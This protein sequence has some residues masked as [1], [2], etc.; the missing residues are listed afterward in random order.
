MSLWKEI[1]EY[2]PCSDQETRLASE[3][4]S[5]YLAKGRIT[6]TN[7]ELLDLPDPVIAAFYA[8]LSEH[9]SSL[10]PVYN[11]SGPHWMQDAS[12]CFI[13]IR[14]TG[15][16]K[17]FG[18]CISAAKLLPGIRSNA[19]HLG[20]FTSYDFH[21]IYAVRSVK[22]VARELLHPVLVQAGWNG[23]QHIRAL[24]EAAHLLQKTIGFDLEPHVTQFAVPVLEHPQYFRWIRLDPGTRTLWQGQTQTEQLQEHGQM[25][26]ICQVQK[27]VQSALQ[28]DGITTLDTLEDERDRDRHQQTHSRIINSLIEQGYWTVPVQTWNSLGVPAW[29]GYNQQHRYPVFDYRSAQGQDSSAHAYNIVTPFAWYR[30]L[31]I[32][33]SCSQPPRLDT[34]CLD[35]YTEILSWWQDAG[36]DFFRHDSVDHIFDSCHTPDWPL[37][38]RPSPAVLRHIIHAS[39]E[40]RPCT[41]HLAER[42]GQELEEYSALGYDSLL[43]SDMFLLSSREILLNAREQYHRLQKLHATGRSFSLCL[44]LDTHDTGNPGLH[45]KPLLSLLTPGLLAQRHFLARFLDLNNG[46]RN[47]YEVMGW[48]DRSFGLFEANVGDLNL[49][50]TGDR[51]FNKIYHLIEDLYD[52]FRPALRQG[53]CVLLHQ[54]S[55]YLAWQIDSPEQGLICLCQGDTCG[56]ILL[57]PD[58]LSPQGEWLA[59]QAVNI[60]SGPEGM[61]IRLET[62]KFC[63]YHMDKINTN[64]EG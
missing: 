23:M 35:F 50:W 41:G 63:L 40:K 19:V 12:F 28:D 43:G 33:Q 57:P 9:S 17:E 29:Q 42:M 3:L 15:R 44:A 61:H 1:H 5:V 38:D 6:Q 37:A 27:Q 16:N 24:I 2:L 18:N 51:D 56:D 11:L 59:P 62:N 60:R 55:D 21:C 53:Q 30:G 14:A 7:R 31:G 45:G 39:R 32:N 58:S 54:D 36:F 26:I 10:S 34:A 49:N 25:E 46:R 48:S 64:H 47:L 13:N 8:G 22:T 20:P 52:R 4:L